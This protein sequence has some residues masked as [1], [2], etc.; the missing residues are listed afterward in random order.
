MS[1]T[2]TIRPSGHQFQADADDTV[3]AAALREGYNLPYGC[4]NGACGSCKGRVL[5]G[6]VD[7]GVY[8]EN[9][10][11]ELERTRGMALFCC[12]KPLENV[13]IECREVGAA[14]D[15]QIRKMPCR[16]QKLER[17]A[18]DVLIVELRLPQSER[19][20]YLAG[21]YLDIIMKDGQRRS[22]SMANPPHADEALQL[23]IR[24]YGGVFSQHAFERMRERDILRFEGP[25]GSFFLRE[26]SDKP[27]ILLA[28]GTGFAPIKA[29]VEHAL[30]IASKRPM[31]LYW[32]GRKRSDLYL[33]DLAQR[34]SAEHGVRFVPV[35]SDPLPDDA[36]Q[37]RTGLVHKAV[38]ED[39]ADLS[40]FQI[41]ACGNPLMVEAARTEFTALCG[42]PEDEFFC[43]AFTAAAEGQPAV[44]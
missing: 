6:R 5:S 44:G 16:V 35:L 15:I 42:L 31:A 10:L 7:Y 22:F 25:Y 11:T 28:S 17:P 41:Y 36:W 12:A 33:H 14:K 24:N 23:H 21:Q 40:G 29:I 8:Q 4:R 38:M 19:L 27:I 39:C 20:Q 2:I 3:L 13:E 26:D 1:V 30:H 32:G 9:A 37:G 34:W 18:A 43:D